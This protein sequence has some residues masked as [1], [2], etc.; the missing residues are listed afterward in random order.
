MNSYQEGLIKRAIDTHV[1]MAHAHFI[2]EVTGLSIRDPTL[3]LFLNF[4]KP[5]LI[6]DKAFEVGFHIFHA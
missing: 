4:C 2:Y 3:K 5:S 1:P 6:L